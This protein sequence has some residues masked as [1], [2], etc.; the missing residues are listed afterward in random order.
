[1]AP[2]QGSSNLAVGESSQ[3]KEAPKPSSG[4]G[5]QISRKSPK[6]PTAD[7]QEQVQAPTPAAL[8]RTSPYHNDTNPLVRYI[9]TIGRKG[10]GDGFMM[11][12]AVVFSWNGRIFVGDSFKRDVQIFHHNGRYSGKLKPL[13]KAD[14]V[15]SSNGHIS[16]PSGIAVDAKG[17]VC[18]TD[19]S[20]QYIRMFD[21]EGTFIKDLPNHQAKK[22][23]LQGV[24]CD[25]T[26]LILVT[27]SDNCCVQVFQARLDLWMK[28]IGVKGDEE[29]RLKLP[30]QLV[31]DDNGF[32][33]VVDYG[34]SMI[35]VF[36]KSGLPYKSFGG[37]GAVNGSFNVPRGIAIDKSGR[38]Y[39]SDSLNHRVQVFAN[40]GSWLYTFGGKG[41]EPGQFIGPSGLSI[42][43]ANDCLYVADRNNGRI[44]VFKILD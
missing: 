2:P 43:R 27:D 28:R 10:E 39:V 19:F 16:N 4:P 14:K 34:K 30:A 15:K 1:M 40:D 8:P 36:A 17:R 33:Y 35:T 29:G 37:R 32:I 9:S 41:S 18:V 25:N 24:F 5:I 38:I 21:V 42:D 22:G 7:S 44:Q 20:D 11:E 12:P 13:K 3:E 26:N 23:G 31:C 6:V